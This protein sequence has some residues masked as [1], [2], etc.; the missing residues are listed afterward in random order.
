MSKQAVYLID[1]AKFHI[2]GIATSWDYDD[3]VTRSLS[4]AFPDALVNPQTGKIIRY[5]RKFQKQT[6]G[7]FSFEFFYI[8]EKAANGMFLQI[9]SEFDYL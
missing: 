5:I 9:L 8:T 7:A 3:R 2:A 6:S 1:D 4:T